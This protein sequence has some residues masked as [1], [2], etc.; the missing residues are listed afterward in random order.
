MAIY[1]ETADDLNQLEFCRGFPIR[2]KIHCYC[3]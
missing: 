1:Y 2:E 3:E